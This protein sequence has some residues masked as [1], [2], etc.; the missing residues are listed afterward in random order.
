[1]PSRMLCN[2]AEQKSPE[3]RSG[4][5]LTPSHSTPLHNIRDGIERGISIVDPVE[6]ME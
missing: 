4:L 1:M 5:A 3:A 6:H 2:G